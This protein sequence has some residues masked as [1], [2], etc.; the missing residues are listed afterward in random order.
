MLY[1]LEWY[2]KRWVNH[3]LPQLLVHGH[4]KVVIMDRWTYQ[5][6]SYTKHNTAYLVFII[7]QCFEYK[8]SLSSWYHV[9]ALST[10]TTVLLSSHFV[11][12]YK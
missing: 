8:L 7:Y 10:N 11:Q 2:N 12:S 9:T 5:Y 1:I 3:D 6:L 4:T